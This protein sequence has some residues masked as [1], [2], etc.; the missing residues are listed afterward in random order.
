MTDKMPTPE[1]MAAAVKELGEAHAD[2]ERCKHLARKAN[3]EECRASNRL[4][5]A[6]G[7]LRALTDQLVP[8]H[9]QGQRTPT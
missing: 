6:A 7:K 1:E 5:T 2:H 3:S 8:P 9:G 4:E